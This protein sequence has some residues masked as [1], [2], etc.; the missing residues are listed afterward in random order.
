MHVLCRKNETRYNLGLCLKFDSKG[1]KVLGYSRKGQK[2][3]EFSSKAKDLISSYVRRFPAFFQTLNRYSKFGN[4]YDDTDFFPVSDAHDHL[5]EM[6]QWLKEANVKSME[7][8]A[9]DCEALSKRAVSDIESGIDTFI[10]GL[11][12][13]NSFVSLEGVPRDVIYFI[14]NYSPF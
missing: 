10:K 12:Q 4:F 7:T 2:A 3:W 9:L 13:N 1:R 14:F 6:K 8:V 5:E 11:Q